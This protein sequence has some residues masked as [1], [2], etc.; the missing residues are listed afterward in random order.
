ME[1]CFYW[2]VFSPNERK[3]GPDQLPIRTD[4]MQCNFSSEILE[5]K[6]LS[7]RTMFPLARKSVCSKRNKMI[8]LKNTFLLDRL[9][10]AGKSF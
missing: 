5:E 8:L 10:L 9:K 3:Y 1:N 6:T 7:K 4:F 2:S